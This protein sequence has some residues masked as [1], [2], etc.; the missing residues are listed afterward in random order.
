M[1]INKNRW[2]STGSVIISFVWVNID[3]KLFILDSVRKKIK[4]VIK[5]KYYDVKLSSQISNMGS[6]LSDKEKSLF[7]LQSTKQKILNSVILATGVLTWLSKN[8]HNS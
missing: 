5:V 6:Y 4:R 7:S 8:N 3:K 2:Q 1:P